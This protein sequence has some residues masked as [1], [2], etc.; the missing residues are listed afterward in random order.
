MKERVGGASVFVKYFTSQSTIGIIVL[1]GP[2][3]RRKVLAVTEGSAYS[4][5]MNTPLRDDPQQPIALHERAM[6]DLR[7]IRKTMERAGSFTA[8]P[9]WGGVGIGVTA[10]GAAWLASRQ[11][12]P[13]RW[14]AVWLATAGIATIIAVSTMLL[15]ARHSRVPLSSGPGRKFLL[16]FP[17]PVMAA[18]AMTVALVIN[19]MSALLTALWLLSYGATVVTAGAVS[20]RAVPLMGMAFMVMGVLA[21]ATPVTWADA[22]MAAGFGGLHIGFGLLIARR[23]GG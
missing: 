11:P 16:T 15:K 17:A 14:L 22:W 4:F 19:D 5:V 2:S 8:V 3:L 18:V 12:S 6:D 21:L 10:L 1:S 23:H 7:F 20:V 9:G 13:A